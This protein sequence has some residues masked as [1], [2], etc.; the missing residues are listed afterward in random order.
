MSDAK[1]FDFFVYTQNK[2]KV[3]KALKQGDIDYVHFF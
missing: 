2:S 1:R 3:T